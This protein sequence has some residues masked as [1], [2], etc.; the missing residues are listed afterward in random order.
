MLNQE[1]TNL[2]LPVCPTSGLWKGGFGNELNPSLV[3]L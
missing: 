1:Q 3:N 2:R